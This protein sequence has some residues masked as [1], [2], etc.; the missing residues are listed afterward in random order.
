M[1]RAY[2]QKNLD[3]PLIRN[4]VYESAHQDLGYSNVGMLD[5]MN[6]ALIATSGFLTPHELDIAE[7]MAAD[8]LETNYGPWKLQ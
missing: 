4:D 2:L 7:S 5:A 3:R 8:L 6:D 1:A